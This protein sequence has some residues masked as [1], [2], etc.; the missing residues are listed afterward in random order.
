M[1][2][3]M[4]EIFVRGVKGDIYQKLKVEAAKEGIT[5]GKALTKAIES[6]FREKKKLSEEERE[7]MI[8]NLAYERLEKKLLE[9]HKGEYVGIAHGKLVVVSESLPKVIHKIKKI[10]PKHA[11]ITK[12]GEEDEG[13]IDLG[14]SLTK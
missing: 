13:V 8:N 7:R 14:S 5:V 2:S 6:W 4:V 3:N 9:E 12:L 1:I 11:I 10:N